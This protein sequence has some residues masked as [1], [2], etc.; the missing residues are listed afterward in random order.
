M[1]FKVKGQE[2]RGPLLD[3]I[4]DLI[5]PRTTC[6]ELI[7][8]RCAVCLFAMTHAMVEVHRFFSGTPHLRRSI[9][10]PSLPKTLTLRKMNAQYDGQSRVLGIDTKKKRTKTRHSSDIVLR[11]IEIEE[12]KSEKVLPSIVAGVLCPVLIS[13]IGKICEKKYVVMSTERDQMKKAKIRVVC[14][15]IH[16]G[17]WYLALLGIM[18]SSVCSKKKA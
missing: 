5:M 11:S 2:R 17:S 18:P 8:V 10:H 1:Q 13:S 12:E 16:T 9:S 7:A 4:S 14:T 6:A 15:H 3:A